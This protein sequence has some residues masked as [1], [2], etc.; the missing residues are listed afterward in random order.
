MESQSTFLMPTFVVVGAVV[1]AVV[2][3]AVVIKGVRVMLKKSK[4][5]T[6]HRNQGY[7]KYQND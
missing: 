5:E 1:V 3:I 2:L 6:G 4:K 7:D